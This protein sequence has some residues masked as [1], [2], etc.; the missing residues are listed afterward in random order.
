ML[1][2]L[3]NHRPMLAFLCSHC[4]AVQPSSIEIFYTFY[5]A[6]PLPIASYPVSLF[7]F[8]LLLLIYEVYLKYLKFKGCVSYWMKIE[9]C[10]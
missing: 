8:P 6:Q 9:G 3:F 10:L 5:I 1:A 2:I 4:Q 7:F